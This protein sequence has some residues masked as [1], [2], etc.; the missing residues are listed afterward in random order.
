MAHK[1][2][3]EFCN[4]M[5]AQ[6]PDMFTGNTILDVG[7]LDI[8]GN[9]RQFFTDIKKYVGLDLGAGKNVDVIS[10]AHLYNGVQEFDAVI[11]TEC[12]EHDKH[13]RASI[14][15]MYDL[16]LPN[17]MMLITIAGEGRKEHGTA[18]TEPKSSPF[19]NDYY[20]NI[21]AKDFVE[22]LDLETDFS[23][24]ELSYDREPKDIRFFGIK[25]FK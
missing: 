1:A 3:S 14:K 9:N 8:N 2:Q 23:Y 24:W 20:K 21:T 7:S 18:R 6:F 5:K 17:G 16:L 11:S 25:N 15:K 4:R 10:P 22:V 13:Y 12:F 19:T